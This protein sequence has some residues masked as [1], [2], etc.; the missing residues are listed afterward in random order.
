MAFTV[1]TEQNKVYLRM[2]S[3]MTDQHDYFFLVLTMMLISVN[4]TAP[5]SSKAI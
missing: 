4:E 3:N 5:E 2:N 1:M